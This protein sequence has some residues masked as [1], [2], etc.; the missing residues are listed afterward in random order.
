M[1][2]RVKGLEGGEGGGE[3][4]GRGGGGGGFKGDSFT[5]G[6]GSVGDG[7][8]RMGTDVTSL[9]EGRLCRF[10]FGMNGKRP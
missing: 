10:S 4:G 8:F 5:L 9:Q 3:V 6:N 7:E 1:S 2:L